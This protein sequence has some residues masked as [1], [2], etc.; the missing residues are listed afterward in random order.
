MLPYMVKSAATTGAYNYAGDIR[1]D[2]PSILLERGCAAG[3][4]FYRQGGRGQKMSL[5]S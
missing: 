5:I 2:I 3:R 4:R 1:D